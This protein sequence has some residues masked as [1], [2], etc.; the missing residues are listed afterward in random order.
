MEEIQ[1]VLEEVGA[2]AANGDLARGALIVGGGV[3]ATLGTVWR[4]MRR[5]PDRT[6]V[7]VDAPPGESVQVKV[8]KDDTPRLL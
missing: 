5:R 2:W 8:G 4:V 3:L 6:N 1:S 7:R